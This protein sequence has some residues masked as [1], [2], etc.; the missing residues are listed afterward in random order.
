[1]VSSRFLTKIEL[2]QVFYPLVCVNRSVVHSSSQNSYTWLN[3]SGF[4]GCFGV[5]FCFVLLCLFFFNNNNLFF[6]TQ[7]VSWSLHWS[8]HSSNI[9]WFRTVS[10][11][12]LS[13]LLNSETNS[14]LKVM[15]EEATERY[16]AAAQIAVYISACDWSTDHCNLEW[17]EEISLQSTTV[18]PSRPN[19]SLFW[20]D[21]LI[22]DFMQERSALKRSSS[23]I[24]IHYRSVRLELNMCTI[25]VSL[26]SLKCHKLLP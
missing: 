12:H 23:Y 10:P 18:L 19:R 13:L 17:K 14:S 21:Y 16:K 6:P 15:T 22:F 5:L 26:T 11:N 25:Y 20:K 1:M 9:A 24:C 7:P 3:P 2:V 4:S 8:K